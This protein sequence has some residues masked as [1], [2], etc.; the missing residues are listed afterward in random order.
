MHSNFQANLQA[1]RL[2]NPAL[3]GAL[4]HHQ[5][6]SE[7]FISTH[8][9]RILLARRN[10][11]EVT[12][13]PNPVPAAVA[14]QLKEKIFPANNCTAPVMVAGLDQGWLWHALFQTPCINP[15]I[16]GHRPP[17]YLLVHDLQQL[18]T[19]L[20]F[21]QWQELLAD[22]R[23]RVF[24]GTD[25]VDQVRQALL[26]NTALPWP[27][28]CLTIEPALWAPNT[29]FDTLLDEITQQATDRLNRAASP[30]PASP[31]PLPYLPTDRPLR[32]LGITSRYTTFLQYSMRD[33]LSAF[34]RL[35]HT[36]HLLI[37][38]DD[39]ELLSNLV[40]AETCHQ[41]KPDLILIIDHYRA[42]VRG[43]PDDVPCVMWI[44]DN[45]SNIF[46]PKAG[47]AQ[48]ELDFCL[49]FGK[50][51][52]TSQHNYPA[53]RFCCATI[54][55]N[56]E[57]FA[58]E[59]VSPA[60]LDAHRCDLSFVSHASTP[61][62]DLLHEAAQTVQSR[63]SV[64]LLDD[65]YQQMHA[66][67]QQGGEVLGEAWIAQLIQQTLQVRGQQIDPRH[68]PGLMELFYQR[69]NNALYRHQTLH[70]A[71]ELGVDLHL[72]GRGWEKH[73][74]LK[75]FAR[76]VADNNT[77]LRAIYQ[78][79]R[80][81]LQVTPFGAVHQRLLDGL[82]AG[83]FFLIRADRGDRVGLLHQKL[84][85][86]CRQ[87]GITSDAQLQKVTDPSIT[88]IMQQ[89]NWLE[90][91]RNGPRIDP[92]L[93][94]TCRLHAESEFLVSADSFWPQF[95]R[96]SFDTQTTL[97]KQVQHFL[98][99][100]DQRLELSAAMRQPVAQRCTYTAITQRL[101]TFMRQNLA[102]RTIRRCA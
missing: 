18:W 78:A 22:R 38:N 71:A 69:I 93:Y 39:H 26:D 70:W 19:V 34:D 73:P 12:I 59:P 45:L 89:I 4:E 17:L 67:Y 77:Q 36:T 54:G 96:V 97:R 60:Q 75:R 64:R 40:Y 84:W 62:Q 76:G 83:G 3:A 6:T 90:G 50:Y 42:E 88:A 55:V 79:S 31:D 52:L 68:M 9:N 56:D 5:P 27:G 7:L 94:E 2:S 72:Y 28:Y 99:N 13:L 37:E 102:S 8:D 95:D 15:A 23:S 98:A 16:N 66:H 58:P 74:T 30:R 1:L 41:F 48:G 43:L 24:V 49:G 29:N 91:H 86:Y 101:L 32:V 53:D 47:Q 61:A 14:Q 81:N 51:C 100:T 63:Q 44:Q 87:H 11:D 20:H 57:R 21:Q 80:I 25:A 82:L 65:V 85:D 46:N 35:G 92:P 10:D 33:W